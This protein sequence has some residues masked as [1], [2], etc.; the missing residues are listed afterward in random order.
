M[1][2]PHEESAPH[3][4]AEDAPNIVAA[5]G[6]LPL[7]A[8]EPHDALVWRGAH[9]LKAQL[10]TSITFARRRWPCAPS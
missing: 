8:S 7:L 1:P 6:R 10:T 2:R 4:F 9:G 5:E 3:P